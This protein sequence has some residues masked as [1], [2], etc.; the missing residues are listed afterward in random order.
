MFWQKISTKVATRSAEQCQWKHQGKEIPSN[1]TL[2]A[3]K[4]VSA[5]E[6]K[7][8]GSKGDSLFDSLVIT[9]S[10]IA[11]IESFIIS[12]LVSSQQNGRTVTGGVGTIKRKRGIRELLE[13]QDLNYE[14]DVFDSTPFKRMKDLKVFNAFSFA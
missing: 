11:L 8:P 9:D 2:L 3:P 7:N 12:S 1:K 14:D 4:R 13:R 10:C 6:I 5:K